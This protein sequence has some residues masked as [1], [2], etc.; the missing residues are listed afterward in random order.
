MAYD[1]DNNSSA[2]SNSSNRE[3][4]HEK[5][6]SLIKRRY[7]DYKQGKPTK[8]KIA[9]KA[10]FKKSKK[11]GRPRKASSIH[12]QEQQSSQSQGNC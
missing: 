8:N 7:G 2:T 11:R 3:K 1:V 12:Q 5:E 4:G 6:T 9:S 10:K